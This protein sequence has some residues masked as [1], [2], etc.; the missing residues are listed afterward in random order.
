MKE[1]GLSLAEI[2]GR[3]SPPKHVIKA[4]EEKW[5]YKYGEPLVRPDLV[6]S[7]PTQMF[8]LHRWYIEACKECTRFINVKIKDEHYFRGE[9]LINI[10]VEELYQLFHKDAL[11][12]SLVSCWC[13]LEM[14]RH[15]R[16]GVYDV[17]FID[18][19]VVHSTNVVD[20]AEETEHNI[21]WFL[22]NVWVRF[23]SKE[24]GEWKVPLS[25]NANKQRPGT[26]LCAFYVAESIISPRGQRTYSALSNLEYRRYRV[27]EEDKHKAIQ[28]ALAGF[29]NDEVL[30]PKGEHYYDGRLEPASVD[31][32]IDLDDPNYD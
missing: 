17:G 26:N 28:E 18:P 32:N 4:G 5:K 11:D 31:Y 12:K 22:R 14:L 27:A 6:R 29:L 8:K 23:T 9:D 13:L 7:L 10:D 15:K 24:P 1:T 21:L 2:T 19:Y 3:K 20:Q 16:E 25:V 30:D